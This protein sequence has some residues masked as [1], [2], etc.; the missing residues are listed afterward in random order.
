MDVKPSIRVKILFFI[1]FLIAIGYQ[2][3]AQ[4]KNILG[5]IVGTNVSSVSDYHG[6]TAVGITGGLYWEWKVSD[7]FSLQSNFL[8]SQRGEREDHAS[9]EL[10]LAYMNLPIMAKYYLTDNFQVMAGIFWDL[11]LGVKSDSYSKNELQNSDFGIPIGLSYDVSNN[12]QLGL[13]YNV[14]LMNI[15]SVATNNFAPRN[16]WGNLTIALLIR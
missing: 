11:L 10:R 16:N 8:Y 6:K 5:A 15:S 9:P 7:V 13:S 4:N 14:G 3:H 12:L 2:T 1:P